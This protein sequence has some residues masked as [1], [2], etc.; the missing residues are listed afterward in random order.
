LRHSKKNDLRTDKG[1]TIHIS[2]EQIFTWN[3][4]RRLMA[5]EL[6]GGGS[7]SQIDHLLMRRRYLMV[8]ADLGREGAAVANRRGSGEELA[9][10]EQEELAP[11]LA[12]VRSP[13]SD[14][15][16]NGASAVTLASDHAPLPWPHERHGFPLSLHSMPLKEVFFCKYIHLYI[17]YTPASVVRAWTHGRQ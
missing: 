8:A 7:R 17:Y 4:T 1:I 3:R 15:P 13:R 9:R 16:Y 12:A 11:N 10:T 5:M 2:S 6:A 14:V